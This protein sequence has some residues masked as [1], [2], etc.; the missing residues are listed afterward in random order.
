MDLLS[1]WIVNSVFAILAR[2]L[3]I[4]PVDLAKIITVL[5]VRSI[6]VIPVFMGIIHLHLLAIPVLIIVNNVKVLISARSVQ[7]VTL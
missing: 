5:T 6:Y 3:L 7:M 1:I 4:I 2:M